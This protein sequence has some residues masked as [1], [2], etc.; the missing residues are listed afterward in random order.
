MCSSNN[1]KPF[2]T[3]TI[4]MTMR[5]T[6]VA[7]VKSTTGSSKAWNVQTKNPMSLNPGQIIREMACSGEAALQFSGHN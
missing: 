7:A 6:S 1:K 2:F 4:I 3:A 5:L